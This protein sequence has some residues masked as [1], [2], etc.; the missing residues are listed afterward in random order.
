MGKNKLKKFDQI[1]S[2]DHVVQP[3]FEEVH[4]KDYKLKGKWG[5][6]FFKNDNPIVLE[7]GCGRGEY[8]VGLSEM[9]PD[10]N[11]IG[12]DI[13][14]ARLWRGA[15]STHEEGLSN[16]GFIRTRIEFID[17]FFAENEISEIWITFPDPQLKSRRSKKRLTAP[18]FLSMYSKM[19]KV[20]GTVNLKTDSQILHEYTKELCDINKFSVL[21]SDNDIYAKSVSKELQIKTTYEKI[22][23]E[24]G[25]P[26]TYLRF[27]L[28]K[29]E[30]YKDVPTDE[31]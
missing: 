18:R 26:I 7:L 2:F 12:I 15:L 27:L 20:D 25:L 17:S 29:N 19:L 31:S 8:T 1:A 22:F 3:E 5:S 10:K 23:L 28:N 30:E 16:A 6:D 9:Y 14:G 21:E 24:E 4:N 13:K 11:I